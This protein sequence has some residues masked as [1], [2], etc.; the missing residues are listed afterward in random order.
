MGSIY[1][2]R[3]KEVNQIRIC[4]DFFTGLINALQDHHYPLPSPEEIF[5]KLNIKI[6][7]NLRGP[8]NKL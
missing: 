7:Q 8:L 3:K 5:N 6:M 2:P 4:A 1:G